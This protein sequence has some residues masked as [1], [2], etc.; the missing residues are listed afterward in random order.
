MEIKQETSEKTCKIETETCDGPLNTFKIEIT[1]EPKT[2]TEYDAFDYLDLNDLPVN[3]EVEHDKYKFTLFQEK[4]TTN[5]E[6]CSQE[7]NRIKIM[8]TLH[9]SAKVKYP[10]HHTEEKILN[11]NKN[12]KCDICLKQFTKKGNLERHLRLHT[13]EKPN[14]CEICLKQFTQKSN[15]ETHFRLHTGE[16]PYKCEICLKQFS[17]KGHL[18]VHLRLHTGEKPY[19]CEICF[20]KFTD[21]GNL[22]V[23]LRVHT[24]EKPYKC[25]I[26]F[27]QFSSTSSLKSHLRTHNGEKPH[28]C[29]ICLK[30]FTTTGQLRTH[31]GKHS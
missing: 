22:K 13:G 8:E 7:E 31:S 17:Y 30:Q 16:K 19:K 12:K 9:S 14:Q 2:E 18:N 29:E 11:K 26:C 21:L 23:H 15:L 1:E 6:S 3:T 24:G 27:K 10:G 4:Q 28:K 20:K 5:E 25:E